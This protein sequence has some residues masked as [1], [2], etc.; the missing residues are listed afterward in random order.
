MPLAALLIIVITTSCKTTKTGAL[1]SQRVE[2]T[3]DND[4]TEYSLIVLDSGFESY[5]A[6]QPSAK[7]YSQQYYENWNRQYVMEWNARNVQY[8]QHRAQPAGIV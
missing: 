1:Q 7:F 2:M 3:A 4:S 5:L 8:R 6:S